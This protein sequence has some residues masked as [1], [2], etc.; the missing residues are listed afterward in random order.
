MKKYIRKTAIFTAGW[1]MVAIGFVGLFTPF[2]QG[3]FLIV[4]GFYLL[5]FESDYFKRVV[6]T[7][8][9]RFPK[10]AQYHD[11][12]EKKYHNIFGRGE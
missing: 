8:G 7:V 1:G 12:V 10:V 5:S 9:K 3:I 11:V 6:T 2:L 4:I